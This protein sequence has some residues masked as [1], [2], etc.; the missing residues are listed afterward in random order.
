MEVLGPVTYLVDTDQGQRWKRHADQL[1][2]W[3]PSLPSSSPEADVEPELPQHAEDFSQDLPE[4]LSSE[5]GTPEPTEESPA[6][7]E[8][9]SPPFSELVAPRYLRQNH[10]RPPDRYS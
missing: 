3:L 9:P 5:I 1:K 6:P 2:T 4:E 8:S 7:S 10:H